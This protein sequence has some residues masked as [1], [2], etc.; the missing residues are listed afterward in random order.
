MLF[1][2]LLCNLY[3]GA[4]TSTI[5]PSLSLSLILARG[6]VLVFVVI[7]RVFYLLEMN[8]DIRS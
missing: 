4:A 3:F 7:L 2:L 8:S 5:Y 6:I 1:F